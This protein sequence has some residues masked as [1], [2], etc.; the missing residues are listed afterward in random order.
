MVIWLMT[1]SLVAQNVSIDVTGTVT[2]AV[3]NEPVIGATIIVEGNASQGT[4]TD[5]D[6]NY[7]L[8]G[9]PADATLVI[10]YVG[11]ASQRVPV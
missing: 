7:T 5:I 1:L 4:V 9:V 10:S 11:Y 2:D 3:F 8:T 6:G